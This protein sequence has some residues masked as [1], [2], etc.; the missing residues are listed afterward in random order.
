MCASHQSLSPCCHGPVGTSLPGFEGSHEPYCHFSQLLQGARTWDAH[1]PLFFGGAK[2]IHSFL[3]GHCVLFCFILLFLSSS[4]SSSHLGPGNRWGGCWRWERW[5][6][7]MSSSLQ[8]FI[9]SAGSQRVLHCLEARGGLHVERH[10]SGAAKDMIL[11]KN[12][13]FL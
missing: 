4:V 11:E 5:G 9:P 2:S 13:S 8:L 7:A 3:E 1:S 6:S 12:I 10:T